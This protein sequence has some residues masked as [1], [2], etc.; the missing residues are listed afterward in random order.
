MQLTEIIICSIGCISQ[1]WKLDPMYVRP[2]TA[3]RYDMFLSSPHSRLFP[4]FGVTGMVMNIIRPRCP[5]QC[6]IIL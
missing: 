1:F 4:S 2:I 3:L 5:V 6:V